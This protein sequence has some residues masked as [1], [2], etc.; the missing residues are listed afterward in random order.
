MRLQQCVNWKRVSE[1]VEDN[2]G[3]LQLWLLAKSDGVIIII[4]SS[5]SSRSS[6]IVRLS[7]STMTNPNQGAVRLIRC[8]GG[9]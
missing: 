5:S 2:E 1:Y 9:L 3:C 7:L 4:I 6:S 8:S